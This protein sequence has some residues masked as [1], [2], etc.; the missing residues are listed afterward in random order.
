M[1]PAESVVVMAITV[2]AG[3]AGKVEV[4]LVVIVL[5]AESVVVTGITVI[6]TAG[7]TGIVVAGRLGP[8][9]AYSV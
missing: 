6:T 8:G 4:T 5:P 2:T 9:V 1:L 3:G 7:G